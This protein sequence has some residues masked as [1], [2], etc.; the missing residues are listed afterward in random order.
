MR[1]LILIALIYL[2]YR[3]LKSWFHSNVSLRPPMGG[4]HDRQ[5]DDEMIKDPVCNVYFPKRDGRYL[6]I[7]GQNI[8]FCSDA[9]RD[10]FIASGAANK[11]DGDVS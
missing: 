11:R 4:N 9:C 10:K 8:Y 5:I 2:A 3:A 7:D 6:N 1:L